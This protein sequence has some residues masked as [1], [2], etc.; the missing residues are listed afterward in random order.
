METDVDRRYQEVEFYS[1]PESSEIAIRSAIGNPGM[2]LKAIC[3]QNEV[4][5]KEIA[6]TALRQEVEGRARHCARPLFS[7]VALPSADA[8][9]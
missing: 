8:L 2:K 6:D 4:R 1:A 3:N 7:P 5:E 9:D